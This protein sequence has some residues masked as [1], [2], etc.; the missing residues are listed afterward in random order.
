VQIQ[1]PAGA[2]AAD[3][4]LHLR[5]VH[6]HPG[7]S[8]VSPPVPIRVGQAPQPTHSSIHLGIGTI[9][10]AA[11]FRKVTI[12]GAQGLEVRYPTTPAGRTVHVPITVLY[13][14]A[15]TYHYDVQILDPDTTLWAVGAAS[16]NDL[17]YAA[18]GSG[19]VG[20]DLTLKATGPSNEARVLEF[21]A[22]RTDVND[23]GFSNFMRIPIRGFT[24]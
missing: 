10:A 22:R 14:V 7:S 3:L 4:S 9:G 2:T 19:A 23:P 15:G 18:G 1:I 8:A 24:T 12:D 6:N 16:P 17:A 21:V 20:F 5:S 11:P 13:D